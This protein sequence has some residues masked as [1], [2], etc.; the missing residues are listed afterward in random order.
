MEFDKDTPYTCG[1]SVFAEL[2]ILFIRRIWIACITII[3]M[4]NYYFSIYSED[5]DQQGYN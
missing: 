2:F 3:F 4:Y 1:W 5:H